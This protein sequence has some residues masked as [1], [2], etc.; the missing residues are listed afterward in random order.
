VEVFPTLPPLPSLPTLVNPN[1]WLLAEHGH[2]YRRRVNANGS[3]QV[4]RHSS[5]MGQAFAGTSALA[6][7]N[8][9]Q[10]CL[11]VFRD[12]RPLR[13]FSL[14]GLYPDLMPLTDYLDYLKG[15]A[16]SIEQYRHFHW[17]QTGQLL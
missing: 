3:I 1:R 11:H 14:K 4:D 2:L 8:T 17:Q 9:P 6:Q 5:Y 7:L 12:G 15:E 13:E 10:A 16:P